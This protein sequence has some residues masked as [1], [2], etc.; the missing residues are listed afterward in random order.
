MRTFRLKGSSEVSIAR[1][2]FGAFFA[3]MKPM[4]PIRSMVIA[5]LTLCAAMSLAQQWRETQAF[6][7]PADQINPGLRWLLDFRTFE[8]DTRALH[9]Q[10]L[11][12][13]GELSVGNPEGTVITLPGYD[14]RLQRF[15]VWHNSVLGPQVQAQ[16]PNFRALSGQGI[17]DPHAVV[18]LESAPGRLSAMVLSPK[19][20]YALEPLHRFESNAV[21][22]HRFEDM[23][24][25]AAWQ[26]FVNHVPQPEVEPCTGCGD[27]HEHGTTGRNIG[28][29]LYTFRIAVNGTVEFTNFHGSEA[30]AVASVATTI[31]RLDAILR[32]D[33]TTA[34]TLVYTKCWTGD[35]ATDPFTNSSSSAMLGQS[36]TALNNPPGPGAAAYDLGHVFGTTFGGVAFLDSVGTTNKHGG[37]SG[38]ST[39][40]NVPFAH[41]VGHEV[42]HM[43]GG[44]HT[45]NG[46]STSNCLNNRDIFGAF[47]PG[48]GSTIMSYA[49][50]CGADNIVTTW[51]GYYNVGNIERMLTIRNR[52]QSNGVQSATGNSVP[53]VNAGPDFTIPRQTPFRLTATFSDP[54]GD[55]VTLT[56]E[57]NNLPASGTAHAGTPTLSSD[58]TTRPLFRSFPPG[59]SPTR[60][61]PQQSL[62]L[63]N[64][65]TSPF[66]FLPNQDRTMRFRATV[67]D[68]RATAGGLRWDDTIIT[69]S[70]E[71][72]RVTSPNTAVSWPAGSTQTVTWTVGGGSVA[73]NVNILLS[74]N[75]G[76]S[77]FSGTA[78]VLASNVPN[79]GSQPVTLPNTLTSSAR[80]IIEGAG[81]IFFD[82]S[83]TNFTIGSANR[84]PV[85]TNPG[86]RVIAEENLLAFNLSATDPDGGQTLTYSL[87]A[88][89][90]GVQVSSIGQFSWRPTEAQGPGTYLVTV[91]VSDNGNPSLSASQSFQVQVTEVQKI[92]TGTVNFSTAP[93]TLQGRTVDLTYVLPSGQSF[94]DNTPLSSS[95]T[96]NYVSQVPA[97]TYR[98]LVD[99]A[100]CLVRAV[101]SFVLQASGG[102]LPTVTLILGDINNDNIIDGNDINEILSEFGSEGNFVEDLN[103]DGIVDGNDV[104]IAL[105]NFGIEGDL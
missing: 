57:Q 99:S 98:V 39:P 40:N 76:A 32:R 44:R 75:G 37:V 3:L 4:I 41:L 49:G 91:Q 30:N 14:G 97:D 69:V 61:F 56:W 8:V 5:G 66:E 73:P 29:T 54:D 62:V 92:V 58:N 20:S 55:P 93:G 7:P 11:R 77:Y 10:L 12:A 70:G 1:K 6:D 25:P 31:N 23:I 35:P 28:G 78:T 51:D 96:F 47:E 65:F 102:T 100:G 104:N 101:P 105:S 36:A 45:F 63:A 19:G 94:T 24:I 87:V 95:S 17:D 38:S 72:F 74:T 71:P 21:A 85:L 48:G 15:R 2:T 18:R 83:D 89:P 27:T 103:A 46:T 82:T 13:P 53:L 26:C 22:H 50:I 86:N 81:N 43:F 60:F 79:D 90:P 84:A 80:I 88:G 16:I 42:G 52:A 64:N 59:T 67:R 34:L 33:L 68:N 9:Q